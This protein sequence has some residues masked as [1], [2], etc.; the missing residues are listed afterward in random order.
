MNQTKMLLVVLSVMVA[1]MVGCSRYHQGRP[2][3]S[4]QPASQEVV[5]EVKR[6]VEENVKDPEKSNRVQA[7]VQNIIKEVNRSAQETRGFHEQLAVLNANYDAPPEQFTKILDALNNGRM[8]SAAKILQ[9]RFKIKEL[10]SREEWKNLNDAMLKSR[11]Q[12]EQRPPSRG[13]TY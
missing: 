4:G 12:R 1:S 13:D 8:E 10:L 9:T 3:A 11:E 5:S 6:V 7:L 2:G